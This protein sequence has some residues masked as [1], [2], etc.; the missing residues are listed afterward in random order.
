MGPASPKD[1]VTAAGNKY[2]THKNDELRP[3]HVGLD[4]RVS[5]WVHRKRD[6]GNLL[7]IDLRDHY[8]LTQVVFTPDSDAFKAAEAVKLESVISVAG[9]VIARTE[10]N[11]NPTLPTG[12][13]EVVANRLDVLSAAEVLP[14]QVAGTQEIPEEQ[15]LRYRFLDLRRDKIH[16]NVVLRSKV[17]SSI[18]RRMVEQGFLDT[19]RRFSPRARPKGHATIW[20]PAA[21]TRA[22]S[23]PCRRHRSSSS[24]C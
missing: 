22:S 21:F 3:E 2:R 23:T 8:G 14:F 17:I 10:E 15:R 12:R 20:F 6:H 16:S 9:K 13:I 11:I 18:R 7:F 19:R 4:V 5:G 24:S 1:D